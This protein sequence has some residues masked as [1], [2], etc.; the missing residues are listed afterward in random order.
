LESP[1]TLTKRK[2][3]ADELF[4]ANEDGHQSK[5][6]RPV[7]PSSLPPRSSP[8]SDTLT[9]APTKT[10]QP[11]AH[12]S[13]S[14]YPPPSAAWSAAPPNNH[15]DRPPSVH[16]YHPGYHHHYPPPN[17]G[18]PHGPN[19]SH[20]PGLGGDPP[21]S[22]MPN[23]QYMY[24]EHHSNHPG[25]VSYSHSGVNSYGPYHDPAYN[26]NHN[27]YSYPLGAHPP[28]ST[29]HVPHG[30]HPP[31]LAS[32]APHTH[33]NHPPP[34]TSYAPHAPGNHPPPLPSHASHGNRAPG[35]GYG[36]NNLPERHPSTHGNAL[37]SLGAEKV[38][39]H[40]TKG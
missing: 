22:W 19:A 5:K 40:D 36:G 11:P 29:P 7:I 28:P 20:Q 34:P 21:T 23:N 25:P 38:D 24:P 33:G 9:T 17:S 10:S 13:F 37:E 31:P 35:V 18:P 30:N 39:G 2:I 3:V 6:L 26:H 1:G 32:Y 8:G 12:Q 16:N 14:H 4:P 27:A 15:P